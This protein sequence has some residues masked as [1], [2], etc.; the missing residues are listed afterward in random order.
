MIEVEILR[1][2]F[3]ADRICKR[4]K[5]VEDTFEGHNVYVGILVD[6]PPGKSPSEVKISVSEPVRRY[7]SELRDDH[8]FKTYDSLLRDMCR[9]YTI[10][11]FQE[12]GIFYKWC[13]RKQDK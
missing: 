13:E 8:G 10:N 7:L 1:G 6:L 3:N 11:K 2:R 9:A 12:S 4:V 5:E